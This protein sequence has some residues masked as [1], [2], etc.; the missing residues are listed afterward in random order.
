[1]TNS[2]N[3][4]LLLETKCREWKGSNWFTSIDVKR[5]L[6]RIHVFPHALN[7]RLLSTKENAA[8]SV[9][10]RYFDAWS[11]NEMLHY[12]DTNY[13]LYLPMKH[14]AIW[15]S[16]A[17]SVCNY[18]S[19]LLTKELC[20]WNLFLLMSFITKVFLCLEYPLLL[21]RKLCFIAQRHC[22]RSEKPSH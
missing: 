7:R 1:M 4:G 11:N 14:L 21:R 2:K 9:I 19:R 5:G 10:P 15:Q 12:S 13:C 16:W 20:F 18:L 8:I 17:S 6:K 3:L 22:C